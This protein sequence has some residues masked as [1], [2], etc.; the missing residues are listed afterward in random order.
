MADNTNN[1]TNIESD[2]L[3]E[4]L[5]FLIKL[6]IKLQQIIKELITFLKVYYNIKII[7]RSNANEKT[8]YFFIIIKI[9][10]LKANFK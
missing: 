3:N 6:F 9:I 10:K 8:N 1:L 7:I 2:L 4:L 5:Y